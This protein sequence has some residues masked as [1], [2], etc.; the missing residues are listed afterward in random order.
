MEDTSIGATKHLPCVETSNELGQQ[1]PEI[2][3]PT[4][5]MYCPKYFMGRR[6]LIGYEER[7]GHG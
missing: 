1:M 7:F 5:N 3:P 4:T 2:R 6:L